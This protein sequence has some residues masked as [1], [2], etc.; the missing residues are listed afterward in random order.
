MKRILTLLAAAAL[1]LSFSA[2]GSKTPA[3]VTDA[4]S[5][6]AAQTTEPA[7]PSAE[8]TEAE[9][10]TV[11]EE[12]S[13]EAKE[14]EESSAAAEETSQAPETTTAAEDALPQTTAE[15]LA[16]Y[17]D[18]M[19]YAKTEKAGFKRVRYQSLPKEKR[20]FSNNTVINIAANFMTSKEKAEK[21]PEV[22]PKGN[23]GA[24][25]PIYGNKKGCLLTDT[26]GIQSAECKK[27]PN[28]N[29]RIKIVLKPEMNPEPTPFGAEKAPSCH[30]AMFGP[31][32]KKEIDEALN[33]KIVTAITKSAEYSLKYYDS[34]SD[35]EYDPVTK[36]I[37]SLHQHCDVLVTADAE[38]VFGP[39]NGSC[40]LVNEN[41]FSDLVY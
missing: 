17:T 38:L 13:S 30:G 23:D 28:G 37:Q 35:L 21:N 20:N 39:F 10:S 29:V 22:Y 7:E 18:V 3:P 32:S 34:Y 2:C 11:N 40:V 27:L 15:I 12:E 14:A 24:A 31:A 8:T 6:T 41:Y 1:L 5:R 19:T 25:F 26:S 36:H 33:S 4:P 16:A 9:S